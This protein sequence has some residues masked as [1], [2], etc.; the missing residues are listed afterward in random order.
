MDLA[1]RMKNYES[2][3]KQKLVPKMPAIIRVDGKTF[4][5][6]TKGLKTP[7]D[8]RF[9]AAMA[10]TAMYMVNNIQGAVLA[11]GQSDEISILMRDYDL[12]NSQA[13]FDGKIQK[14]ASVSASMATANFNS[15]AHRLGIDHG[16]LAFFDSRVFN[17]PM[18]D[19]INYF[20]WRQ[21]DFMRNSLQMVARTYFSHKELH[22]FS[23]E[24]I[25]QKLL[26]MEPPVDW[27]DY[28]NI[29]KHGYCYVK[30]AENIDLLTPRFMEFREYIT[31]HLYKNEDNNE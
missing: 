24:G 21:Q 15:S 6:W 25:K 4:S 12:P 17:V 29:Y 19:V 31:F 9:Y 23:I 16:E 27:H 11:Y 7:F 14:I 1:T 13:W 28:E 30:G 22:G 26:N 20:I 10:K 18:N 8:N 5:S 2:V 3:F